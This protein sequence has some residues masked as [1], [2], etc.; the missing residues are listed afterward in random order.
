MRPSAFV[1]WVLLL[2]SACASAAARWTKPNATSDDLQ[3]DTAHCE[4]AAEEE[5]DPRTNPFAIKRKT[6]L[7]KRCMEE[8]GWSETDQ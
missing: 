3:H 5:A 1:V 6:D 7:F 4:Q 8:K 2:A